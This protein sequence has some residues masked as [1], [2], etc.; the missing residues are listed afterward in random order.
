M[1]G[2]Q[3][4]LE[5][6]CDFPIKAMGRKERDFDALVVGIV[7]R[8]CPDV[9]EGAVTSRLS[10]GGNYV[11]VTVTIQARSRR[12]LD[13]IYMDLTAHEKVLMAL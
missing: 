7:R 9:H 3:P 13:N 12:Q 10:R 5:F 11:S 8:H 4:L 1:T 6:P 2:D